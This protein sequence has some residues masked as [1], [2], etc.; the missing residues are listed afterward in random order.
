M[1]GVARDG[2][3]ECCVHIIEVF[4]CPFE[5]VGFILKERGVTKGW[6]NLW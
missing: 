2:N 4:A 3:G 5:R 1:A 6:K